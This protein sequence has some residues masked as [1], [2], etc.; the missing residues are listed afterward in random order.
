MVDHKKLVEIGREL[1][2]A[3]GE[4]PERQGI[5]N[6]PTRF[7]NWWREF[8]DY[9][10]GNTDVVFESVTTDQLVVVSGMRVWSLC[11]H[12]LLP[13]WCDVSVGYLTG[14]KV[15]GLSKFAR[16]A[17]LCAHRLQIQERLVHQIADEVQSITQTDN[18]AVVANGVH[19][20]MAMRGIKTPAAMTTS[21]LRGE[22]QKRT[23][24][25]LEFFMST[26]DIGSARVLLK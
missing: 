9:D 4:N 24:L 15:L 6:T 7:A 3:I 22:F 13:F 16:I 1:L 23:D 14:E 18:V 26:S 17:H 21:V 25:K 8:I 19:M 10:P 12:H 11:E 2:I 20:C 5:K